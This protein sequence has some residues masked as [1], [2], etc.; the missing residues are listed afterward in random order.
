M[1]LNANTP[2]AGADQYTAMT[3]GKL[4]V[5]RVQGAPDFVQMFPSSEVTPGVLAPGLSPT[6]VHTHLEHGTVVSRP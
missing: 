5:D 6:W 1:L 4:L 2:E 3:L